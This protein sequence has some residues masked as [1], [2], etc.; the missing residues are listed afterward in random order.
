MLYDSENTKKG[1][2]SK[3]LTSLRKSPKF[4]K[5]IFILPP[6]SQQAIKT[7]EIKR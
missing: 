4:T 3:Y 6:Q 7:A 1:T 2:G 5:F